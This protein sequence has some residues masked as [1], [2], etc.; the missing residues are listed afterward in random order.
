MPRVLLLGG[1]GDARALAARLTA[2]PGF[3]LVS[4]LAGRVRAP[5]LPAG[6]VRIGGF[7]GSA[8]LAQWL[9]DHRIDVVVDATHPF[10]DRI[11][12]NAVLAARARHVPIALVRRPAWVRTDADRWIPVEDLRAA[13]AVL[14]GIGRRA[15]L[16]VG[17]QGVGTFAHLDSM[18]FL[19]RAIDPPEV[20]VPAAATVL[21][22][23]GPFTLE[24]ELTLLREHRI[25]VLV[26]KNSGGALTAAKLA[27]ARH[28][29]VPVVMVSRTPPPEG[30][31]VF[32]AVDGAVAWLRALAGRARRS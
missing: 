31:P 12:A 10:A 19:I 20:A 13:A 16:T 24:H 7:G 5:Q 3:T 14:P 27:A 17:R 9:C 15:F 28:L 26:T 21:L 23:R 11:T 22:E 8:G 6:Q 4:S 32:D 2:E 1:T 29:A 25:D 18:W 30:V